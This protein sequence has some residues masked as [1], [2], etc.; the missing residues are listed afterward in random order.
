MAGITNLNEFI[1]LDCLEVLSQCVVATE[2]ITELELDLFKAFLVHNLK[3]SQPSF[4]QECTMNFKAFLLRLFYSS[5]KSHAARRISKPN[6]E[7]GK[8]VVSFINWI[9]HQIISNLYPGAPYARLHLALRLYCCLV[10]LCSQPPSDLQFDFFDP[11][12]L[13]IFLPQICLQII[14][15][16]WC[17]YDSI[18]QIACEIVQYFPSPIPGF[19]L[20]TMTHLLRLALNLIC[21]PKAR[22]CEGGAIIF[23]VFLHKYVLKQGWKISGFKQDV[24]QIE[25]VNSK[26][27]KKRS[28]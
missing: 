24:I 18:R 15:L 16:L 11:T 22:E 2:E 20:P 4:R 27:G 5:R 14:Q 28:D 7:D 17:R 12:Q 21:S 10:Q 8:R 26:D 23:L 25:I 3:T 1:A 9:N 13:D 19:E 6:M